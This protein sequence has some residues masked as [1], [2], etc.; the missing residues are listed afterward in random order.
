VSAPYESRPVDRCRPISEE[1]G[2]A[3]AVTLMVITI[4]LALAAVGSI[5][6]M[7]SLSNAG[8]DQ[9]D[10]RSLAVAEAGAQQALMRQNKILTT[11]AA[12]CLIENAVGSLIPIAPE[13]DGWCR[14]QSGEVE[15]G[16]FTYRAKPPLVLDA[17]GSQERLTIVSTGSVNGETRRLSI[18][19]LKSTGVPAFAGAEVAGLN[20]FVVGG[21]AKIFANMG[22]NASY[23]LGGDAH[24]CGNMTYGFGQ[25]INVSGG[26]VEFCPGKEQTEGEFALS[27]ADPGSVHSA[28]NNDN[29]RFFGQD[30]KTGNLSWS[31]TTRQLSMQSNHSL[32]LG[33][34]NYSLCRLTM[35]GSSNIFVAAG[36]VVRIWFDKPEN[37][38][39][40]PGAV[41]LSMTGNSEMSTTSGVPSDLGLIFSGESTIN[42]AGDGKANELMIYAPE[43]TINLSGKGNYTGAMASSNFGAQGEAQVHGH[44]SVLDFQL[45]VTTGYKLERFVECVGP[46]PSGSG[47]N[48]V[49]GC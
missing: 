10:K 15:G 12:P 14:A 40:P 4:G 19:A 27:P 18:D 29:G 32:T 34:S 11:D 16:T 42:L 49:G 21:S 26:G 37:C 35:A 39:L 7:G 8:R 48:P 9:S 17:L 41:Q 23:T 2:V 44:E 6:A 38:G 45:G 30:T 43:S 20:S 13:S 1:A 22:T 31:P 24:P 36:A 33:G 28:G 25:G 5:A 46:M 47:A 3:V